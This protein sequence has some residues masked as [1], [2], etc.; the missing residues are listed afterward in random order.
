MLRD[1]K[2]WR[3][4]RRWRTN[5]KLYFLAL[6]YYLQLCIIIAGLS[7]EMEGG[8]SCNGGFI[9]RLGSLCCHTG[10]EP[11]GARRT[12]VP[13][14]GTWLGEKR[15]VMM[16]DRN[17]KPLGPVHFWWFGIWDHRQNRS[18]GHICQFG[19]VGRITTILPPIPSRTEIVAKHN[20]FVCFNGTSNVV[21]F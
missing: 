2:I 5:G 6:R 17:V 7:G 21:W 10:L 15:N 1:G 14:T 18:F 13:G 11:R 12:Y 19:M 4:H 20:T 8:S 3:E 9:C 16:Q